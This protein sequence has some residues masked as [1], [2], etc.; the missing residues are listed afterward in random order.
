MRVSVCVGEYA[1]TPYCVPELGINVFSMEELCYCMK[2][3]VFLLDFSIINDGLLDWIDRECGLR[4]LARQLHSYAHKQGSLSVFVTT[5]LRYVGFLDE[6]TIREIEQVLKRGAGLS[7]IEK[8]RS[9]I[10]YLTGKKKYQAA[11]RGYD[12]LLRNWREQEAGGEPASKDFLA[13]IWHN[14]G[15]ACAGLM[16]YDRAAECFEKA[17]ELDGREDY[18]R[19]YLAAMRILLSEEDYVALVSGRG[20]WYRQTL[21]LE[22]R[23][24]KITGEW[25]E[26]PDYL[27]LYN[28]RELRSRDKQR[29]DEENECLTEALKDSYRM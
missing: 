4:E 29:Y 6:E 19:D 21:E 17:V 15:V 22:K 7:G 24:E 27:R 11:I 26:Q 13:R 10:D 25:E 18:L 3:N 16:L 20:E 14:K 12:E 2:E 9:Q 8:R 23:L 28:R 1:K 5:I